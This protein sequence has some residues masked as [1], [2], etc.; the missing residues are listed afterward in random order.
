MGARTRLRVVVALALAGSTAACALK[1][2]PP[3]SEFLGAG[4][5]GVEIPEAWRSGAAPGAVTEPWLRT[6]DDARLEALVSDALAYN[7]DLLLAAARVDEA[8]AV[9]E[10]AGA[11]LVPAVD[12]LGRTGGKLGGDFSGTSGVLLKASWEVDLWG[13]VRYAR[14]AAA[15]SFYATEFDLAG[16]RQSIAALVAKAWFVAI[17]SRLQ[18][19]LAVQMVGDS[20]KVVGV[21]EQ[22]LSIGAGAELDVALAK[23]N[24][25]T[26]RDSER[27]LDLARREAIRA[28]ETLVGRYPGAQ[29][30][31]A[32]ALPTLG[33]T[34]PAG[35]PSELL[36]RR[37]DV[38]AAR[39]RIFAAFSNVEAAQAA[40]LP[41]ISLTAGLSH[42]TSDLFVLEQRDDI[43]ES[44]GAT[45][46]LPIFQGG[47]LVAQVEARTAQQ[48][49][50]VAL[51]AQTGL[52]A[53]SEVESALSSEVSLAEREPI[54]SARVD[55]GRRALDLELV[56]YRVGSS[57]LRPV[58]QQQLAL[59][60]TQAALLRVQSERR[61]QR[62][63]LQQALGGDFGVEGALATR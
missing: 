61:I 54:L 32:E 34:V 25:E 29:L 1:D 33:S 13:R 49:Q 19:A 44:I 31:V 4:L 11:K 53:F 58:L 5:A 21:A 55:L 12:A 60:G 47:E 20:E 46:Y 36:E 26:A 41:T 52:R 63:N 30:D 24:L 10:Q 40:R 15:E 27:Q 28:L 56:R 39:H 48:R 59:Y 42:I 51:W 9:L 23:Q 45:L 57:D 3:P 38:A 37:L 8:A 50:A 18:H 62:V 16:A 22:R 2:P 6:F 7:P 14:R 17:E 43:V 35:V